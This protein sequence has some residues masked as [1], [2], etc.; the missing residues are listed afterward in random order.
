MFTPASAIS[1]Q[2]WNSIRIVSQFKDITLTRFPADIFYIFLTGTLAYVFGIV[3]TFGSGL[4]CQPLLSATQLEVTKMAFTTNC[5]GVFASI[6][7]LTL[8]SAFIY[9]ICALVHRL[10][11]DHNLPSTLPWAGTHGHNNPLARARANMASF[12]S[13]R[14]LLDEGYNEVITIPFNPS[15]PLPPSNH[16]YYKLILTHSNSPALQ[17]QPQ[18]HPPLLPQRTRGDPAPLADPVAPCPA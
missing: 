11:T 10:F 16:Q 4:S 9:T 13:L 17:A 14:S 3:G 15:T 6:L 18:L 1:G 2:V 8:T 12:F 7:L 5:I